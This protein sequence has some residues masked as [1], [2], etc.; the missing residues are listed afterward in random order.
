MLRASWFSG[1]DTVTVETEW[2]GTETDAEQA[3]RHQVKIL[4]KLVT[5]PI[6]R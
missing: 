3:A 4:A 5:H 2:D 6:D 1:G